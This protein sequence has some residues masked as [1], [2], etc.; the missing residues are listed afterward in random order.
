MN[1]IYDFE[2]L[3]QEFKDGAVLGL[4]ALEYDDKKFIEDDG[5]DYDEL[6]D[7]VKF[8]KFDV[9]D[10]VR[11][12]GRKINPD[13]LDW[14]KSQGKEAQ[15]ILDPSSEDVSITTL[16]SWINKNF[17]EK[18]KKVFTRGNTFDPMF[19]VSL[20][21]HDPFDWCARS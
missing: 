7:E 4:A 18:Y 20:I 10:Q 3:S 13:T 16:L 19:L 11:N 21:G 9:V 8:I 17:S 2:T 12:H 1:I 15:K 14:W 5:Y 6:I